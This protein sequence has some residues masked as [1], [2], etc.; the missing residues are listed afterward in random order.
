MY[1]GTEIIEI[2]YRFAWTH[3]LN[4][5]LLVGLHVGTCSNTAKQTSCP[6]ETMG[7]GGKSGSFRIG[8]K[9]LRLEPA[10]RTEVDL[11]EGAA[12][13]LAPEAE[14]VG[15]AR[16]H[17]PAGRT[18]PPLGRAGRGHPDTGRIEEV[19][20]GWGLGGASR[21]WEEDRCAAE[22]G[23]FCLLCGGRWCFVSASEQGAQRQSRTTRARAGR[24]TTSP[25][26]TSSACLAT[27]IG[28]KWRGWTGKVTSQSPGWELKHRGRSGLFLGG[29][30]FFVFIYCILHFTSK[31]A[32]AYL[33]ILKCDV[34]KKF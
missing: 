34:S 24:Q 32:C 26:L 18:L 28:G 4:R 3:Q 31:H 20:R 25:H 10:A 23:D 8:A 19:R 13:E 30:Y 22:I 33:I 12:P 17:R 7:K 29:R 2:N 9:H 16:L 5:D 6:S 21:V 27:G 1:S 11:P 15:H 14:L